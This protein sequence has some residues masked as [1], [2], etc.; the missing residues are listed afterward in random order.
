MQNP[1]APL[2][3]GATRLRGCDSYLF[4]GQP[5]SLGWR[6]LVCMQSSR[7]FRAF[8]GQLWD[9]SATMLGQ[10]SC[11]VHFVLHDIEISEEVA[12]VIFK[13]V[14]IS[15]QNTFS[16]IVCFKISKR[17]SSHSEHFK[18][19]RTNFNKTSSVFIRY[20]TVL[21]IGMLIDGRVYER[22]LGDVRLGA[23]ALE[24]AICGL[25]FGNF[26]QTT[27]CWTL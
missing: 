12:H 14:H 17:T 13:V 11:L 1:P 3:G 26:R 7:W 10:Q 16:D 21:S 8:V 20:F 15:L 23:S 24:T 27:R 22:S 4:S 9:N 19:R 25:Q 18:D 2:S 6:L 5:P